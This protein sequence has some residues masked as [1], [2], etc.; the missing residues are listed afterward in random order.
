MLRKQLKWYVNEKLLSYFQFDQ[1]LLLG[2]L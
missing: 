2:S 1:C